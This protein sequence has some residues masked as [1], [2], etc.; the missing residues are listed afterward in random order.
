MPWVRLRAIF[1]AFSTA[2]IISCIVWGLGVCIV[3][4]F[5]LPCTVTWQ[6][7]VRVT[8]LGS[9]LPSLRWE[10]PPLKL[11]WLT[12]DSQSRVGNLRES[13][14]FQWK[15][16][17]RLIYKQIIIWKMKHFSSGR[18]WKLRPTPG[19]ASHTT[20]SHDDY[21]KVV[22][23]TTAA[24][25]T[26]IKLFGLPIA[27]DTSHSSRSR[28]GEFRALYAALIFTNGSESHRF[29]QESSCCSPRHGIS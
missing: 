23:I 7:L 14:R 12:R 20:D 11:S 10:S 3:S 4:A 28:Q 21:R 6:L 1:V 8:L 9:I 18:E 5:Q 25:A 13:Q 16:S 2:T 19:A 26:T 17:R 24:K 15:I 29:P 22:F 27:K